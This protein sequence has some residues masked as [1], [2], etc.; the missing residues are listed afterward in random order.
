MVYL[1][2]EDPMLEISKGNVTGHATV[3]KFGENNAVAQDTTEDIWDGGGTYTFPATADITHIKQ[4]TDQVADRSGTVEVQGLDTSWVLTVQT[5]NLDASDTTTL[6]ALDTAL[7][8]VFRMKFLEDIV[9][10]DDISCV[11]TGDTTTYATMLA[12]NNQT[13][14]AIYTVPASKTAYMTKYYSHLRQSSGKE[15]KGANVK[16]WVADRDNSYEFMIKHSV[17]IQKGAAGTEHKFE[18]YFKI[19][20]KCDIKITGHSFDDIGNISAGFD[21]VVVDD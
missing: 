6:V 13:L 14:M 5:K 3:N 2:N 8:R 11:N 20:A 15:P 7:R 10:G 18:P 9:A 1:P 19:N 17:G 21:L 16:L 4:A 12:G